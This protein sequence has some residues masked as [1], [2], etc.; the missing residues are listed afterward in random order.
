MSNT[1]LSV[2]L[3]ADQR[4]FWSGVDAFLADKEARM[5]LLYGSAGTGK[6]Q[7]IAM[8][9]RSLVLPFALTAPTNQAVGVLAGKAGGGKHMTI[10]KAVGL[11]I[12]TRGAE[13]ILSDS[14][15]G[16]AFRPD[17]R[18]LMIVDE[19]SMI[20]SGLFTRVVAYMHNNP[21][22]KVLFI[23]DAAQ[24]PP[25]N[26]TDSAVFKLKEEMSPYCWELREVVRQDGGPLLDY[27]CQMRDRLTEDSLVRTLPGTQKAD[28]GSIFALDRSRLAQ[29]A[30]H[31]FKQGEDTRILAW[32][33]A[34]VDQYNRQVRAMVVGE[35]KTPFVVGE[36][37]IVGSPIFDGEEIAF[38]TSTLVQVED[39]ARRRVKMAGEVFDAWDLRISD[40]YGMPVRTTFVSP[41]NK[42]TVE[43]H[44]SSEAARISRLSRRS[45]PNEW[46]KF[47]KER[48]KY[49]D[50][51][52][53][54]AMTVHK[55]Q[56]TTFKSSIVDVTDI[57]SNPDTRERNRLLYTAFSRPSDML[58]Y[59]V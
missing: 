42:F 1:E 57:A 55:A 58:V 2:E 34:T 47:W 3:T 32:R 39:V 35:T 45:Q 16:P 41:E 21:Q 26:E 15:R 36:P 20:D 7:A 10:H 29:A 23:G 48:R 50:V 44:F 27:L 52:W 17:G 33:N 9:S 19:A 28:T 14:P 51:R 24:L 53:A 56:G 40:G 38:Q 31:K 49:G 8:K 30:A 37:A 12:T 5:A 13:E 54:Y 11:T 59:G 22:S 46:R 4:A 43:R 6:T 18:S 25:V